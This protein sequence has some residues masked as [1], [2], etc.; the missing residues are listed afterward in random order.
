MA[1]FDEDL[2]LALV[3]AETEDRALATGTWPER[4]AEWRRLRAVYD[5]IAAAEVPAGRVGALR[6]PADAQALARRL[7]RAAYEFLANSRDAGV[8]ARL[9]HGRYRPF[10]DEEPD[11][12]GWVLQAA[13]GVVYDGVAGRFF[14]REAYSPPWPSSRWPRSPGRR[15]SWR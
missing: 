1:E 4:R 3:A 15:P 13:G 2:Y 10:P 9:C 11:V 8:G 6:P 12:H 7:L 5:V 14:R